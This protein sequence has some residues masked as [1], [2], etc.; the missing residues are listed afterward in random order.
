MPLK[1]KIKARIDLEQRKKGL[2]WHPVY[3]CSFS[4]EYVLLNPGKE[5]AEL[6]IQFDFPSSTA[7][8][9]DFK[10][11]VNG[12][13][14][15]CV[16]DPSKGID[17]TVEIAPGEKKIF[18]VAYE[19]RG[20]K[21]WLYR[22][23]EY[24]GRI[25]GFDMEVQ[26][27]FHKIDF[28]EGSISP[29]IK[30]ETSNGYELIWEAADLITG[31]NI[32][33]LMP[34]KLNPGP[35]V[36]RITYFAPVCLLFFFVL[37]MAINVIYKL[38][39]HPMHYLFI[40]AGFFSFHLLFAYFVDLINVHVAFVISAF[41]AVFLVTAY[42]R[43]ALGERFPWKTA[44]AGEIFY[45]ILFSYSFFVKGMTG[46]IVAVASV[47]TL[48]ALMKVTAKTNWEKV[49]SDKKDKSGKLEGKLCN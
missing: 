20:I 44:L 32:G 9:D 16:V 30:R 47:L 2:I 33:I 43:A 4:G 29:D 18:L 14:L 28:V 46:V 6:R 45:L 15:D 48:A 36:G 25:K 8:Y 10:I 21:E 11:E 3:E 22:P 31:Q 1:N 5:K 24:S 49:F 35:L 38:N 34:E 40:A 13:D 41:V 19:T 37:I 39:V 12:K 26:T 17:Q 42:L 23:D 7:T 27:N